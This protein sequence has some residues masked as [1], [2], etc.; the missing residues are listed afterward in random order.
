MNYIKMTKVLLLH[1]FVL[2]PIPHSLV[3]LIRQ[4]R[5]YKELEKWE[6]MGRPFPPPHMVK[7]RMLRGLSKRYGLK[8]FVETGTCYGDMVYAM[9]ASFDTIYSIELSK[10]FYDMAKRRFSG[11]ENI[12]LIYGDS[13][14]EL[15]QVMSKIDQ[16]ALFWLDGHYSDGMTAKGEKDT[17]IYEELGHILSAQ[18]RGHVIVIDDARNFGTDSA[19]PTIEELKTFVKSKRNNLELFIRDDCICMKPNL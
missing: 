11:M 15:G 1:V 10:N 18:D 14:K 17:P 13:G 9:K 7:Q 19:Y 2:S 6:K 8:I 12:K 5:L 16:P 3:N 4:R